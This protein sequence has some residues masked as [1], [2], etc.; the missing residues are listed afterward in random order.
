MKHATTVTEL[1]NVDLREKGAGKVACLQ[2]KREKVLEGLYP[3]VNQIAYRLSFRLP[4]HINVSDLVD[5]GIVG[6]LEAMNRF[7]SKKGVKLATYA[8][9]RIKGAMLDELRS[10]DW[11]PHSARHKVKG[12]QMTLAELEQKLARTP[13]DEEMAEAMEIS[14]KDLKLLQTHAKGSAFISLDSISLDRDEGRRSVLECLKSPEG[15]S[16]EN[17]L[18]MKEAG[19]CLAKSINSLKEKERLVVSLYYYDDLTLQEIGKVLGLTE[20]RICQIH[21]QAITHLKKRLSVKNKKLN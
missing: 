18:N 19:E 7:D 9:V 14:L 6:L 3:L 13:T 20:S 1:R 12:M 5:A 10:M 11:L 15:F 21:A 8:Y 2:S 16:P 4:S 17:L